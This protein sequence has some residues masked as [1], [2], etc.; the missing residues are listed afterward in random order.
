MKEC[1][2]FTANTFKKIIIKYVYLF[3]ILNKFIL[4]L[5]IYINLYSIKFLTQE[6]LIKNII[7]LIIF[8]I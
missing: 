7:C 1:Y 3:I 2:Y 4:N 8:L 6:N 5:N